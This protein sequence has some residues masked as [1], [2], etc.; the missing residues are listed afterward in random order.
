MSASMA[1]ILMGHWSAST[2]TDKKPFVDK[3]DGCGEVILT[4]GGEGDTYGIDGSTLLAAHQ[5]GMLA[6]NGYGKLEDAWDMGYTTGNA[7]NGRRDA[8]PYRTK[9][10]S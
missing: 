5:T 6:A 1:D 4:W 2:H 10:T 9:E 3:C 7:H 8:N